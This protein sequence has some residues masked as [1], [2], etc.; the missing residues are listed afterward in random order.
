MEIKETIM[1]N[2]LLLATTAALVGLTAI[3]AYAYGNLAPQASPYALIAPQTVEPVPMTEGRSAYTN[4]DP[5]FLAIFGVQPNFGAQL[6]HANHAPVV[7][8]ED[9]TY[10]SRGR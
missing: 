8:P 1:R 4:G 5:G 7:T 10:Y 3:N 6:G 9:N 2:T